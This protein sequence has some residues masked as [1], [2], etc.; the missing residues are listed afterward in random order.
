MNISS[1]DNVDGLFAS[2]FT[3]A[4]MASPRPMPSGFQISLSDLI[5]PSCDRTPWKTTDRSFHRAS[6]N[7]SRLLLYDGGPHNLTAKE[8]AC[9]C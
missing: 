7:G 6:F 2:L 4:S 5:Q 8:Q 9:F 1:L 3:F